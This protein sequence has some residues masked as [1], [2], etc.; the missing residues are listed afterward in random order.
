MLFRCRTNCVSLAWKTEENPSCPM[1][2]EKDSLQHFLLECLNLQEIRRRNTIFTGNEN[3]EEILIKILNPK[4]EDREKNIE[5]LSL[6][7]IARE[8]TQRG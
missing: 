6:M 3:K 1:C 8:T 5:T 2:G 7:W 4:E